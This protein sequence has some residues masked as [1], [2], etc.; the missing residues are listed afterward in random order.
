MPVQLEKDG[1]HIHVK[2]L[3]GLNGEEYATYT[4][5]YDKSCSVSVM[6]S[7]LADCNLSRVLDAIYEGPPNDLR[8]G[9]T[10]HHLRYGGWPRLYTFLLPETCVILKERT[11]LLNHIIRDEMGRAMLTL[12][13]IKKK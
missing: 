2:V 8:N 12:N 7:Y 3:N 11:E 6:D 1:E 10:V 13:V 5:C 4:F 9:L